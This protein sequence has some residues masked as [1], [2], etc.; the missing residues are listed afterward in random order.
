MT[1]VAIP[2]DFA[3]EHGISLICGFDRIRWRAATI[4]LCT[5][6]RADN[7]TEGCDHGHECLRIGNAF[8]SSGL[9][10]NG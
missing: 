7:Q 4:C 1:L 6:R 10:E 3:D 5:R 9:I 2:Y 8:H